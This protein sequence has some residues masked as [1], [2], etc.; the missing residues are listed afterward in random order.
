VDVCR[1]A[2]DV[3]PSLA[4]FVLLMFWENSVCYVHFL[5]GLYENV[6]AVCVQDV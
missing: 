3:F 4:S 5:L 1:C 6:Y 2:Q